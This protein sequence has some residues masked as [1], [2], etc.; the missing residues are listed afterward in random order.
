MDRVG[1]RRLQLIG[2]AGMIICSV[3]ITIAMNYATTSGAD[4]FLIIATLGFVAFF[5]SGP[6]SIKYVATG[7]L[8]TQGPRAAAT[9]VCASILWLGSLTVGLVFPQLEIHLKAFVFLPFC[10]ISTVLF[11]ILF[12]YFPETGNQ[13]ANEVS[14]LFQVPNAWRKA[15]G[16]QKQTIEQP[17][18]MTNHDEGCTDDGSDN[19]A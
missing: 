14:L 6:G 15:I 1:R 16:L 7:E 12:I 17:Q 8:F 5:S 3:I 4:I 13:T 18:E 10:I 19:I 9:S 11:S 2:L